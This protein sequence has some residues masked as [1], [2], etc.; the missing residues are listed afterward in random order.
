MPFTQFEKI[1][2]NQLRKVY[3]YVIVILQD[4]V[5]CN[6]NNI[7]PVKADANLSN[8]EKNHVKALVGK[9]SVA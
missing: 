8:G 4:Y 2:N 6:E 1:H 7:L 3:R 5:F 9:I